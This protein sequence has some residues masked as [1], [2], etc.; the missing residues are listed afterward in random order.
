MRNIPGGSTGLIFR[1]QKI[2][3]EGDGARTIDTYEIDENLLYGIRLALE[4]AR[5]LDA[6]LKD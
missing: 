5:R 1:T 6:Y 4:I 2:I 3:S